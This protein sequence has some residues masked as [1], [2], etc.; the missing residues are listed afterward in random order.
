LPQDSRY[1]VLKAGREAAPESLPQMPGE[2]G[3]WTGAAIRL[4]KSVIEVGF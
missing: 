3:S 2:E 4:L 1:C